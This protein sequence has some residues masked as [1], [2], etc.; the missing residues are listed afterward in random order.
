VEGPLKV[1]G[2]D[3]S[4]LVVWGFH[5]AFIV[6]RTG[7]TMAESMFSSLSGSKRS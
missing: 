2:A 4:D 6:S 1:S 7:R 3:V 5:D